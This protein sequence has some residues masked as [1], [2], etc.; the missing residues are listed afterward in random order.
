M[1]KNKRQSFSVVKKK[2]KGLNM[3]RLGITGILVVVAILLSA[4]P[5]T[6][7]ATTKHQLQLTIT[8]PGTVSS[9]INGINC[10]SDCDED[11]DENTAVILTAKPNKD[12]SFVSWG[13]A[14]TGT[15]LSCTLNM[16]A[17]KDVNAKFIIKEKVVS[18]PDANLR[19]AIK[20]KLKLA[21]NEEITTGDML[22]LSYLRFTGYKLSD[23]EK[24]TSLEGLQYAANLDRLELDGHKISDISPLKDLHE[25]TYLSLNSNPI[26]KLDGLGGVTNLKSLFIASIKADDFN[27]LAGLTEL[28]YLGLAYNNI[29]NISFLAKLKN[30]ET[31]YLHQNALVD[32]SVLKG[33]TNL[34]RLSLKD[35]KI[36]DIKAL[37]ENGGLSG[38]K[39]NVFIDKNCLD[40]SVGG[41]DI[42]NI[43]KLLDRGVKLSYKLQNNCS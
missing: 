30:L 17:D 37:T 8:G 3:N 9:D 11:Y 35:N 1:M 33:L 2:S 22:R 41:E 14:C 26:T 28:H 6:T 24:I 25:L 20:E 38:D 27:P 10:G 4:C 40:L 32:I 7:T 42:V 43:N 19:K 34:S 39:D 12:A 18:I 15:K 16:T 36:V 5:D 13:G 23:S 29:K 31:L 21:A